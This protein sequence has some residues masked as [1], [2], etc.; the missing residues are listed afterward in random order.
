MNPTLRSLKTIYYQY[1]LGIESPGEIIIHRINK[2]CYGRKRALQ[3]KNQKEYEAL[4][5]TYLKNDCWDFNGVKLPYDEN[6]KVELLGCY[7]DSLFFYCHFNDSYNSKIVDL[8]FSYEGAYGYQISDPLFD[9]TVKKGDTVI[10][11]GAWIGDF[12]AYAAIKGATCYAFEPNKKILDLLKT[13]QRLNT[14]FHIVEK[15]LGNRS[16]V[17]Y[18]EQNWVHSGGGKVVTAPSSL[19]Q[20]VEMTTIDDF[21]AE[22]NIERVDFIKADIEG[23]ERFM[24]LGAT[25]TLQK[26]APKLAICTYHLPDDPQVLAKIILEANPKYVV[27]QK[28]CKLY[29]SV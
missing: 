25:K 20:K 22:Q 8:N 2:L 11:A 28:R 10:D 24:L 17:S 6:I 4:K 5:R 18:F 9:V 12:S 16:G 14:G 27:V 19:S 21:V 26:F 1:T 15:G 23:F 3:I 13:T 29:A 7:K